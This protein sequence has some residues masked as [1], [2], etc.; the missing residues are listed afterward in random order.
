MAY[1]FL[2]RSRCGLNGAG[3]LL[4]NREAWTDDIQQL[5]V[6][7][8][9]LTVGDHAVFPRAGD[10]RLHLTTSVFVD[11]RVHTKLR[12]SH[13]CLACLVLQLHLCG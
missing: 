1:S 11:M 13:F 5:M 3:G 12:T 4:L 8:V 9:S 2:H 10:G 7:G 6:L